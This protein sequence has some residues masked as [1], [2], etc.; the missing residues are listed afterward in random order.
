MAFRLPT[1]NLTVLIWNHSATL[2][3][4]TLRVTTVGNLQAG[5]LRG[6]TTVTQPM[7]ANPIDTTNLQSYFLALPARTDIRV[8]TVSGGLTGNDLIELPIYETDGIR[9]F[10]NAASWQDVSKGFATE[11]RRVLLQPVQWPSNVPVP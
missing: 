10:F 9:R 4:A 8:G 3:P 2:P 1:F 6:L 7:G 5:S 11:Y